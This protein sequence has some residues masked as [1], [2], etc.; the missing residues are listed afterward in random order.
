MNADEMQREKQETVRVFVS[1]LICV[2]LCSSVV[3]LL[4]FRALQQLPNLRQLPR[5]EFLV[6]DKM[7]QHRLDLSA[8]DALEERAALRRHGGVARKGGAVEIAI[9]LGLELEGAFFDQA[10][11]IVLM[12]RGFQ[13]VCPASA[14]TISAAVSGQR[15][16]RTSM[17]CH[18]ASEMRGEIRG[19][20]LMRFLSITHVIYYKCKQCQERTFWPNSRPRQVMWPMRG[21]QRKLTNG[22]AEVAREFG[23]VS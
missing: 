13:S 14:S 5:R 15:V 16:Q 7:R 21:F 22:R 6:L 1:Y 23:F 9:G 10:I 2:H 17:T 12:V 11:D 8:E 3:S 4:L 19:G 20:L 18:S